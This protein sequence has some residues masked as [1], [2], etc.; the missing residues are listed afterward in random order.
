MKLTVTY[1]DAEHLV[2]DYLDPLM[3]DQCTVGVG[4]P[5]DWKPTSTPH[6]EVALDGTPR[7]QHPMVMH[8]TIR[9]VAHAGDTTTAKRIATDAQGHLAAATSGGIATRVLTGCLPARDPQTH[10]EIASNTTRVSVRSEVLE[11]S[12]S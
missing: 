4:V 7:H 11:P 9:L 8:H 5:S 1:P 10:H 6:L 12:G 3:G 2:V